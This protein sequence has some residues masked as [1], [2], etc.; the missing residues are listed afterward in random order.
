MFGDLAGVGDFC[1][2]VL[3]CWLVRFNDL[4]L[5]VLLLDFICVCKLL[6][7]DDWVIG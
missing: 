2:V 6:A 4:V 1:F 5:I 7:L 3:F